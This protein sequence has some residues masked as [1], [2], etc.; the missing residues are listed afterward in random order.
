MAETVRLLAVR[1]AEVLV[2]GP[3]DADELAQQ[4]KSIL[5]TSRRRNWVIRLTRRLI[6]AFPGSRPPRIRQLIE[7]MQRDES[8]LR[9]CSNCDDEQH[10][11]PEIDF[12]RLARPKMQPA[13]GAAST[14]SVRPLVTSDEVA[15]W[16]E[17][18][19]GELDWFA[20]CR[21]RGH[22]TANDKLRHYRYRWIAKTSS[23]RR[24]LEIPKPR[25]KSIQRKILNEI[26]NQI[27]P[28]PSAHAYRSG[29]SIASY[30]APN[31]GKQ[32]VLYTDLCEFFPSVRG[33][34]VHAI[35]RTAG[36]PERVAELLS[37]LCTNGT[38]GGVFEGQNFGSA[39][40]R[41]RKRYGSAHL[42]QGSPTNGTGK[43]SGCR[44][45]TLR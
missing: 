19:P 37:G 11:I 18:S 3:W 38:P 4:I 32:V 15:E 7:F 22:Q 33:S 39:T 34:Q 9:L 43:T 30:V 2:R 16:L 25:L 20:D 28:H 40:E 41:S 6:Q 26:L 45:H 42:P 27:P 12:S 29:R 35:F 17:L 10:P 13:A 14:W 36:Y 23:G 5:I 44:L 31:A 21:K 1:L 8:L 24:L